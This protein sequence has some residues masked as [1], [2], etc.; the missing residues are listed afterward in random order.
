MNYLRRL[1][2]EE[3]DVRSLDSATIVGRYCETE[4]PAESLGAKFVCN[5]GGDLFC[6]EEATAQKSLQEDAAHLPGAEHCD[7]KTGSDV[8]P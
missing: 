4:L 2:G 5:R 6:S 3:N 1:Y 7:A 8:L